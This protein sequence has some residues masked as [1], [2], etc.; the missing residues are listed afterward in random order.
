M[1]A[2]GTF[3][4]GDGKILKVNKAHLATKSEAFIKLFCESDSENVC[5]VQDYDLTTFKLFL[6]CLMGFQKCSVLDALLVFPLALK[7]ETEE[8]MNECIDTLKPTTLNENLCVTLNMGVICNCWKL[9]YNLGYF[10]CAYAFI[11]A[12]FEEE[13]YYSLLEPESVKMLL[14]LKCQQFKQRLDSYMLKN[15]SNWVKR[16]AKKLKKEVQVKSFCEI[17]KSFKSEMTHSFESTQALIDFNDSWLGELFSGQEYWDYVKTHTLLPRKSEWIRLRKGGTINE[18]FNI[19][20]VTFVQGHTTIHIARNDF[21]IMNKP[22]N[23]VPQVNGAQNN[24]YN[25]LSRWHTQKI[26]TIHLNILFKYSAK[27]FHDV[28]W[29]ETANSMVFHT[30]KKFYNI[31]IKN[32]KTE[33]CHLIVNISYAVHHDCRVLLTSCGSRLRPIDDIACEKLYFT[34]ALKSF[35]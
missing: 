31:R 8:F 12:I 14:I 7:Y 15:V 30:S 6:D 26:L 16:Y 5:N 34:H 25:D 11:D 2:D 28:T 22:T 4:F 1:C 32:R 9:L 17:L 21:V 33:T 20:D 35:T 10:L 27:V 29:S 24:D 13:K 23:G 18:S 3:K 19:Y